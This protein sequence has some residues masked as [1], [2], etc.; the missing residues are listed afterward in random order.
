MKYFL[1]IVPQYTW[2]QFV[3]LPFHYI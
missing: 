1:F 3:S 2:C